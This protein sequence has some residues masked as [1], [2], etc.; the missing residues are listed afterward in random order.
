M[1]T[2]L[3]PEVQPAPDLATSGTRR[4]LSPAARAAGLRIVALWAIP[5]PAASQL[6]Q[7]PTGGGRLPATLSQE[8]LTRISLLIGIFKALNILFSEP[9]ADRWV[10]LPNSNPLFAGATPL[11][12]MLE[13]GSPGMLAVRRLLDSR[14]GGAL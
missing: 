4:R 5:E 14:R 1:A 11:G 10:N 3:V 12:S 9:L 13:R 8:S 7:F 2:S 6:L